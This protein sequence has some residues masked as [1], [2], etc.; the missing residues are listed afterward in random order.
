MAARSAG[1]ETDDASGHGHDE[2]ARLE[3]RSAVVRRNRARS[4]GGRHLDRDHV[5]PKKRPAEVRVAL[6]DLRAEAGA[7][8]CANASRMK[9]DVTRPGVVRTGVNQRLQF[10]VAPNAGTP[11]G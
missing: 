11:H 6:L 4:A 8:D 10:G 5:L 3:Y 7:T 2:A 9:T 1:M